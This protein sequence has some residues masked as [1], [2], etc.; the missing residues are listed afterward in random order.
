[1]VAT[2]YIAITSLSGHTVGAVIIEDQMDVEAV[3]HLF[4]DPDEELLEL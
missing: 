3:W 4:V 1:M 2:F